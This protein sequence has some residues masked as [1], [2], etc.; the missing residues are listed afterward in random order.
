[1]PDLFKSTIILED[2]RCRPW[3]KERLRP[4]PTTSQAHPCGY[5]R[6]SKPASTPDPATIHA[7][8]EDYRAAAGIDIVQDDAD[9]DRRL[10]MPLLALW[11]DHGVIERCFDA[12]ALWRLRAQDVS[13]EALPCGHYMAEELPEQIAGRLKTFFGERDQ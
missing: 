9:G 7:S 1:M 4:S 13:G 11:G 5:G 2:I 10:P 3:P 6:L 12:L 8:C